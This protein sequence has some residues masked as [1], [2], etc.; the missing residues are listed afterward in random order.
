MATWAEL[1]SRVLRGFTAASATFSDHRTYLEEAQQLLNAYSEL[2]MVTVT[3]QVGVASGSLPAIVSGSTTTGFTLPADFL[4]VSEKR[5]MQFGQE[6]L[7]A[8]PEGAPL[9]FNDSDGNLITG[10]PQ[11]YWVEVLVLNLLPGPTGSERVRLEYIKDP[12]TTNA[13]PEIPSVY[14]KF[15]IPYARWKMYRDMEDSTRAQTYEEA[16][17]GPP[18]AKGQGGVIDEAKQLRRALEGSHS[19]DM[20]RKRFNSRRRYNILTG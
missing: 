18:E 4:G 19:S 1:E 20:L 13:S 5:P 7:L 10:T 14:H 17:R 8:F 16:W 11:G 2:L 15:L 9:V 3:G 12:V 6:P